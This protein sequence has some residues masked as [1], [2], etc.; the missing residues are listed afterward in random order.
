MMQGRGSP[1]IALDVLWRDGQQSADGI[2]HAADVA[3]CVHNLRLHVQVRRLHL[4]HGGGVDFAVF[5]ER[6]LGFQRGIPEAVG[7]VQDFQLAV[8]HLQHVVLLCGSRDKVRLD[9]F[10]TYLC[11]QEQGL[12]GALLVGD[13]AE[14]I[15]VHRE[16]QG[17]VV[18]L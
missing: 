9:G 3:A 13:G 14:G 11:L 17:Q 8:E 16:L 2:L 12:G 1:D 7:S 10:L 5:P 4:I 6:L 18:G 15:D